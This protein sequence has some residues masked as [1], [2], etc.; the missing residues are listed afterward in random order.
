M[1]QLEDST[2]AVANR[3][4]A[5]PQVATVADMLQLRS[6]VED[7]Q[8]ASTIQHD[9]DQYRC[10]LALLEIAR[11]AA[12]FK[13][14]AEHARTQSVLMD[15]WGK[16]VSWASGN[17][18]TAMRVHSIDVACVAQAVNYLERFFD[19]ATWVG[20]NA[21]LEDSE[22]IEVLK[23]TTG[24]ITLCYCRRFDLLSTDRSKFLTDK[25]NLVANGRFELSELA[26]LLNPADRL[27]L[28]QN[29]WFCSVVLGR[30]GS[31]FQ[32]PNCLKQAAENLRHHV[33]Q[34]E[35]PPHAMHEVQLVLT[36]A[37][38][39]PQLAPRPR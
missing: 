28:P 3:V 18:Y 10:R 7:Y 24:A 36:L 23:K 21:N 4:I 15:G 1:T 31:F 11:H 39:V 34:Q 2:V 12:W 8:G 35:I 17:P 25:V 37:D 19:F 14:H 27:C 22:V 30:F 29:D 33:H 32:Q 9:A 5:A 26:W 38:Q 20:E 16:E 13:Q 6:A